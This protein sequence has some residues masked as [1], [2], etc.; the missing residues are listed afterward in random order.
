MTASSRERAGRFR[1]SASNAAARALTLPI[2]M[3]C[4]FAAVALI[5]REAGSSQLGYILI[6]WTVFQLFPVADLGLGAAIVQHGTADDEQFLSLLART[7]RIIWKSTVALMAI[8]ILAAAIGFWDH[9]FGVSRSNPLSLDWAVTL[10]IAIFAASL[11]F[12]LSARVLLAK[13]VA[14]LASIGSVLGAIAGLLITIIL[15]A[16]EAQQAYLGIGGATNVFVAALTCTALVQRR[17]RIP[18]WRILMRPPRQTTMTNADLW[19]SA[20]P[21]MV[22]L[23]TVP[24]ALYAGR[25]IVARAGSGSDLASFSVAAQIHG[26]GYAVIAAG[27]VALWPM[28]LRDRNATSTFRRA[29]LLFGLLGLTAGTVFM[30]SVGL[31]VDLLTDGEV[32]VSILLAGSFGL[33]LLVQSLNQPIAYFLTA[34]SELN[35]Q[36]VACI[37]TLLITVPTSVFVTHRI[38]PA[39]ASFAYAGTLLVVQ[40][41][42]LALW[43]RRRILGGIRN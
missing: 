22:I 23:L 1:G 40:V 18:M 41:A 7:V 11:P 30:F 16:I 14:H 33:L 2:S 37:S 4:T 25:V 3:V 17:L 28:F 6:I 26:A 43:V 10:S 27:G 5:S 32:T 8:S 19:R 21:M 29:M 13:N 34:P 36:A 35:M 39:G 9:I 24:A 42:P 31:F 38:G 15:V 12:G 20:R